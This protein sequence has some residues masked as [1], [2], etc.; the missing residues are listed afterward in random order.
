MDEVFINDKTFNKVDF[1]KQALEKGEYDN[2]IFINCNFSETHLSNITFIDCEFEQC[3][4]SLV[5]FKNTVLNT[6]NFTNCKLLGVDF[7]VCNPFSLVI[8]FKECTLNMSSFYQ[9]NLKQTKFDKCILHEIDF[10]LAN[11]S[12]VNF[13]MCDLKKAIFKETNLEKVD[14]RTAI[15]YSFDLDNNKVNKAQF[16]KENIITLF[17]KY[18]IEIE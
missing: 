10:V 12:Q 5:K 13:N 14:F 4:L 11:L 2:C 7:S 1:T 18:N 6:I 17:N 15:N 3:N 9:M 16:S 8:N